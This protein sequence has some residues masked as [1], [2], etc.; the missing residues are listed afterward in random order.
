[1]I[2]TIEDA[3]RLAAYAK[4]P[5]LGERSWGSYGGLGASGLA[6]TPISTRPMISR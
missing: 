4:Y 3:R 2:N 1:M 5:P 6:R